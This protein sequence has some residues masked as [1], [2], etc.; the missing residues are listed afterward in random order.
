MVR[1][2]A[3]RLVAPCVKMEGVQW[4]DAETGPDPPATFGS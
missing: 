4:T 1:R 3:S 2:V